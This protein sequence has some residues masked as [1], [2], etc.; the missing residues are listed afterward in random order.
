MKTYQKP[1]IRVVQAQLSPLL[2]ASNGLEATRTNYNKNAQD[3][4]VSEEE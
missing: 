3:W 1:T 4:D 2:T